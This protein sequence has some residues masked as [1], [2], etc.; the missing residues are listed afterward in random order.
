M[1]RTRLEHATWRWRF[2]SPVGSLRASVLVA[3]FF[4]C[5]GAA[6]GH[7]LPTNQMV[8]AFVRVQGHQAD[9]IAR[10]PT[11]LL[12]GVPFPT[13]DGH[14]D[15]KQAAASVELARILLADSF[16]LAENNA[17]LSPVQSEGEGRLVAVSD[18][19]FD[20][21]DHAL[22]SLRAPVDGQPSIPYDSGYLI[23]HFVYRVA[24]D[25]SRFEVQSRVAVD[26]GVLAPLTI[27]FQRGEDAGRAMIIQGGANPVD[28]DPRWYRA[29]GGFVVLGIEHILSGTD[30]LLFLLCLV[31]PVRRLRNIV[32]V[33]TA[34]T[35]AHSVTLIVSA[36]GLAPRGAWFPPLVEAAIAASIVYTA[37]ENI[38]VPSVGRRWLIACLFGL[39]HGFGFSNALGDSLQFAGRHLLLSLLAF[40][41]GIEMGQLGVLCVGMPILI[42]LRHWFSPRKV[43]VAL[44]GLGGVLGGVWLVERWQILRQLDATCSVA[45]CMNE[46]VPWLLLLAGVLA[47]GSMLIPLHLKRRPRQ[48]PPPE[49]GIR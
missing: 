25:Q 19:S 46:A 27:R 48:L 41:V 23:V 16:M 20:R 31:V 24:S 38:V 43:V 18:R 12:R 17:R 49:A 5:L 3:L 34:F 8:N 35:I 42:L 45:L 36:M 29:A 37:I 10:V 1:L 6:Q 15:L 13:A 33:I 32:P 14:Y 22:D 30:H 2:L 39:V 7:A 26:V 11:D 21:F 40:N 28:L 9:L 4:A 44:S 47:L